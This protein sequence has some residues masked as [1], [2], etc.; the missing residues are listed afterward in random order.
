M[1]M[2]F[3]DT[4]IAVT[5]TTSK[6]RVTPLKPMT[7]PR[8]ELSAALM[9]SKLM[10]SVA[11]DL[12]IPQDSLFAWTDSTITLCWIKKAPSSLKTFVANRV[13]QIQDLIP[14]AQWRYVPTAD[15]PADLSSRGTS[16][17]ALVKSHLWWHGPLWLS[18]SPTDWPILTPPPTTGSIP[19]LKAVPVLAVTP[20]KID[21]LMYNRF[22]SFSK[23]V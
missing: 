16:P 15:N 3:E 8:L 5:L 6:S 14:P 7:I 4:S 21:R 23:L 18:S 12:K 20:S 13:S 10:N 22:S 1:R 17:E 2:I 11:S 9:M 19:D